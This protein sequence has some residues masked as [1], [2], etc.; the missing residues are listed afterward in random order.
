MGSIQPPTHESA[1]TK[2]RHMIAVPGPIIVGPGCYEGLSART[3]LGVGFDILYMV[4]VQACLKVLEMS[5]SC[6]LEQARALR[7]LAT[8]ILA[9]PLYLICER[10]LR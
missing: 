2:L 1:A 4:R 6:R 9:S 10:T 8:R 3:A 5:D 7:G